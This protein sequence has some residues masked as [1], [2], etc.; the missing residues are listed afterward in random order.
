MKNK[1]HNILVNCIGYYVIA[2]PAILLMAVG[3]ICMTP[4]VIMVKLNGAEVEFNVTEKSVS[5]D[6]TKEES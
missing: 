3:V 6:K 2:I 1:I 5:N 4:A